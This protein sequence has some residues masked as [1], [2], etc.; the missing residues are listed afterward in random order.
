MGIRT[1]SAPTKDER[2]DTIC[3]DG[4]DHHR[5]VTACNTKGCARNKKPNCGNDL[6]DGNMP[7]TLVELSRGPGNSDGDSAGY[8][9]R[10]AREDE[11]DS[12]TEPQRRDNGRKEVLK[13][14]CRK[15]E[16]S[17]YSEDPD[18]GVFC[19]LPEAVP[20]GGV[21]TFANGIECHA[22]D[23]EIPLG[24]CQPPRI[25]REIRKKEES[26][27]GNEECDHTLKDEE[28][29]PAAKTSNVTKTMED[30]SSDQTS[31]SSSKDVTS[32][33]DSNTCGDLLTVV[34]HREKVDRTGVVRS[35]GET[36]EEAGEQQSL[37]VLSQSGK[38]RDNSP[39]HHAATHVARRTSS[40]EEH[41]AGD[42]TQQIAD[43]ED[44]HTG[45]VLCTGEIEILLKIIKTGESD[46]IAIQV[47][48]PVHG[49]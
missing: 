48:E 38:S 49:P 13:T 45:L 14:V 29:L 42:L 28:P 35:L 44:G 17:H 18:H 3:A 22:V 10:R 25:V 12:L 4:K 27:N 23:S 7:C 32:V 21:F 37:E 1:R 9:V 36:Q 20:D 16:M 11:S 41:V 26:N 40:V 8:E 6:G 46:S 47:V 43:E 2:V 39:K 5:N 30:A 31:K 33:E 19:G 34:E 24:L 15:V